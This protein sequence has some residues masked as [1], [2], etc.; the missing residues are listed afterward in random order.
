MTTIPDDVRK[1]AYEIA[2]E[3]DATE[4]LHGMLHIVAVRAIMADRADRAARDSGLRDG[5]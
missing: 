1:L 3:F 2:N 5:G 4:A